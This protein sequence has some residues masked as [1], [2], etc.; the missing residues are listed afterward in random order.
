MTEIPA[1][2]LT[3]FE[4]PFEVQ[5]L[6]QPSPTAEELEAELRALRKERDEIAGELAHAIVAMIPIVGD[7]TGLIE[8]FTDGDLITG[9]HSSWWEKALNVASCLPFLHQ[10][11]GLMKVMGTVGHMAVHVGHKARHVNLIVVDVPDLG[12]AVGKSIAAEVK[13]H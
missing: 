8:V 10:A 9:K 3:L 12:K 1:F 4:M 11:K 5:P 6:D 13:E 7:V 2:A